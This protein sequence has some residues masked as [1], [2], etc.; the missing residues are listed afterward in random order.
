MK[1][2]QFAYIGQA[3]AGLQCVFAAL[4]PLTGADL[5]RR[6]TIRGEGYPVTQAI[7]RRLAHYTDH[8]GQIVFLAKHWN[9]AAWNSLSIPRNRS[10]EFDQQVAEGKASQR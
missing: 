4:E 3:C 6:V 1:Y 7:H 9:S 5:P 2:T 8:I 10:A